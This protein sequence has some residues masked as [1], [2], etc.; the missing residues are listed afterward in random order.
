MKVD[1]DWMFPLILERQDVTKTL[2]N[3]TAIS[4]SLR[5]ENI[6]LLIVFLNIHVINFVKAVDGGSVAP[7][8]DESK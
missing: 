6:D 5:H 2:K 3:V 4:T 7:V 8:L 1:V